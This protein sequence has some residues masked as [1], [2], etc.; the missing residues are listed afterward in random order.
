MENVIANGDSK[1]RTTTYKHSIICGV[2]KPDCNWQYAFS[3]WITP[4]AILD[5]CSEIDRNTFTPYA[6][7]VPPVKML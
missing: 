4:F 6:I 3:P 1:N 5:N 2:A 7:E